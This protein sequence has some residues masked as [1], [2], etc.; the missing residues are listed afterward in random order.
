M[1]Y[2]FMIFNDI[3]CHG[4]RLNLRSLM[5]GIAAKG[6]PSSWW[7]GTLRWFH[8]KYELRP[9]ISVKQLMKWR[10]DGLTEYPD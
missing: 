6:Y 7:I 4:I 10:S 5:W 3:A 8:C 9:V 1:H 2:P